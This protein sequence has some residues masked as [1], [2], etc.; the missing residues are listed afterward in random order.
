MAEGYRT[1]DLRRWRSLD[2][3]MTTPYFIEGFKIWGDYYPEKYAEA[4]KEDKTYELIYGVDNSNA[5]VSDPA[6]SKY[7]R[8]YQI[9]RTLAYDG[10]TWKWH[11][12]CLRSLSNI[13]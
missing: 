3:L 9:A 1:D 12:T 4:A 11:I 10:Y 13:L 5:N 7:V 6:L 2:Q 8:P